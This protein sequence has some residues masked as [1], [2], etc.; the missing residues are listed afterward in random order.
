MKAGRNTFIRVQF[1]AFVI[2]L[3]YEIAKPGDLDMWDSWA[4]RWLSNIDRSVRAAIF[5]EGLARNAWNTATTEEA[6][7]IAVIAGQAAN[8]AKQA[9]VGD[10]S[11]MLSGI[12]SIIDSL[13]RLGRTVD[14]DAATLEA[15]LVANNANE[16]KSII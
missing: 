10:F 1:V 4:A 5:A 2:K 13:T 9:V 7:V 8:I 14:L 12:T 15:A 16:F 11:D 6:K 3:Y